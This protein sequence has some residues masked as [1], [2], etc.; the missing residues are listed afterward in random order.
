VKGQASRQNHGSSP[1]DIAMLLRGG[2]V[3][4][5]EMASKAPSCSE[6]W[7]L[8]GRMQAGMLFGTAVLSSFVN[9]YQV[10]AEWDPEA[11]VWCATSRDV[12]G[13]ATEAE[14][15]EQLT[16]KLRTMVPELLAANQ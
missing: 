5:G 12:P 16:E 11:E 15:I 8:C 1:V 6:L 9:R 7:L 10:E 3:L 14:T 4:L 2:L 13:L